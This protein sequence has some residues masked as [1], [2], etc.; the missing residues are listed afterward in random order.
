M[1]PPR[2]HAEVLRGAEP[3]TT[4]NGDSSGTEAMNRQP[5][6]STHLHAEG[7]GRAVRA[8]DG[9]P[10]R[11]GHR[12]QGRREGDHLARRVGV[13]RLDRRGLRPSRG[14]EGGARGPRRRAVAAHLGRAAGRAAGEGRRRRRGAGRRPLRQEHVPE[15]GDDGHIRRAGA[16]AA[17]DRRLRVEPGGC[18][19]RRPCAAAWFFSDGVRTGGGAGGVLRR[20]IAGSRGT[21]SPSN[22]RVRATL[23]CR[24]RA[25]ATRR[26]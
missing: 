11:V 14:D 1:E 8:G 24:P 2:L 3:R 17:G 21:R 15:P 18:G 6:S 5:I 10:D 19:S 16:A 12:C 9:R 26:R 23:S 13:G 7:E 25:A 20:R 4:R 22:V